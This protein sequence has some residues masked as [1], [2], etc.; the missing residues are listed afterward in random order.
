M[1]SLYPLASTQIDGIEPPVVEPELVRY[2]DGEVREVSVP[3]L[4]PAVGYGS[5]AD[6]PFDNATR[7]PQDV[8]FSRRTGD[9]RWLD[10]SAEEFAREVT[11]LAKGL[12]AEGLS[13][14]DRI[15]V[16]ARTSYEWT[17]T[18]FAAWAAGLVTV[19]V[20]PSFSPRRIQWVLRHSGAAAL[21]TES[22]SQ[23]TAV[24]PES[25]GLRHVWVIDR[26][27]LERLAELG[28]DVPDAEV[29]VRRG[30]LG[31]GTPAS[32]VYTSGTTGRPTACALTHGNFFA[33]VD[34][35][36]ELLFP[37]FTSV[38]GRDTSALL[39]APSA[40]AFGRV[41]ALA[42]VRARVRTGHAPSAVP[43]E[44]L[45]LCEEFRPT[46]VFA[47]PSVLEQIFHHLRARAQESGKLTAFDRSARI[48]SRFAEAEQR[49]RLG[50]GE[51]PGRTLR[52][53]RAVYDQSVYRRLR[54]SLGGR[55]GHVVCGGSAMRRQLSGFYT[56]AGVPVYETYGLT[57]ATG[58]ATLA[59][60][61]RPRLGTVGHPLPGT[62][63][64][65]A[66][67]GEI[68]LSGRHVLHG[69]WDPGATKLLPAAPGGWLPTGDLGRLDEEGYLVVTGR[70]AD[71]LT[72]ISGARVE[73]LAVENRLRAHPLI[74]RAV[75]VGEGRPYVAVLLTL[76]PPGLTH[77]RRTTKRTATPYELLLGDP[78]LRAL[79][80]EAVDEANTATG[81]G[82][83]RFAVLPGEFT[84]TSGHL[85]PTGT[86]R[87][88]RVLGDFAGE[89]EG[90]YR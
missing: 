47:T 78:E 24:A 56:G 74:S 48:A 51:G 46:A 30:M 89:V 5:L 64:R 39:C 52:A 68:L 16:L 75:L 1:S 38:A 60:P 12:I 40:H 26:G 17:L 11:A 67:D 58:I 44:L 22:V 53:A 59:P 88:D 69:R 23:V 32:L 49:H 85:T 34:N 9:G 41:A 45:P 37:A 76:D 20:H 57:E 42:C 70:R 50:R 81:A 86:V 27:H 71:T 33:Q 3:A 31:P 25:V 77:W 65:I 7:A 83:R 2:D 43:E 72:T 73:P 62:A 19:P 61:L 80:Q 90:L 36:V 13:P 55:V 82:I 63:V 29:G 66:D 14:G 18:D 28:A 35:V 79:L 15:A 8:V 4:V 10:V 6:L 21:V 54:A 87:R 84:Q